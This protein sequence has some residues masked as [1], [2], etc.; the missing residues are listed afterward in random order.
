MTST[1]EHLRLLAESIRRQH[2]DDGEA[3][4]V[5]ALVLDSQ[6]QLALHGSGADDPAL[7]WHMLT[8]AAATYLLSIDPT[9]RPPAR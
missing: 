5:L 9:I 2:G 3:A 7:V 8:R 1:S 6:R 4:V